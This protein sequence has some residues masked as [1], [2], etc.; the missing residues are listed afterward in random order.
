MNFYIDINNDFLFVFSLE[1][2]N[3]LD[4][5]KKPFLNSKINF[6]KNYFQIKLLIFFFAK[7][8][9]LLNYLIIYVYGKRKYKLFK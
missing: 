7:N 3:K 2:Q 8:S 9:F 5:E 1:F 4:I 6:S